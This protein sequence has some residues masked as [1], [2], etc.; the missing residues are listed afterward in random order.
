MKV[1]GD[2]C[3]VLPHLKK[4]KMANEGMLLIRP[5]CDVD[6]LAVFD[7]LY[8]QLQCD[9]EM[10]R[11]SDLFNVSCSM[12][13]SVYGQIVSLG[14]I[15]ADTKCA[16]REFL[17]MN[18]LLGPSSSDRM[19]TGTYNISE[20]TFCRWKARV[21]HFLES[22]AHRFRATLMGR[23]RSENINFSQQLVEFMEAVR[24]GK[25][26]LMTAHLVT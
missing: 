4:D 16:I 25:H 18:A 2:N 5:Y 21:S 12:R 7:A 22:S 19:F 8:A 1:H 24:E 15:S 26:F 14:A 13:F 10:D 11:S 23:A 3:F 6:T 17:R 9:E 20:A